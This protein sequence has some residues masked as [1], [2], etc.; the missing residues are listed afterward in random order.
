MRSD[1]W[2]LGCVIYEMASGGGAF[3]RDA[4]ADTLA[5]ILSEEPKPLTGINPDVQVEL[6]RIV[7]KALQKK[8][9]DR[10]QTVKELLADLRR[11]RQE[12]EFRERLQSSI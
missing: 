1:V 5:A 8:T 12:R 7:T 3:A 6:Q 9:S 10:Y 4:G 2:S 11:L